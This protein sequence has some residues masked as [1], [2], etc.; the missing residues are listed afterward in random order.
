L[1]IHWPHLACHRLCG[2]PDCCRRVHISCLTC[3]I[4][5]AHYSKVPRDYYRVQKPGVILINCQGQYVPP[6]WG[7]FCVFT[8]R[9]RRFAYLKDRLLKYV[10]TVEEFLSA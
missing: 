9:D 5:R 10:R 8:D 4:R 3:R 7:V 6:H 1:R 2:I